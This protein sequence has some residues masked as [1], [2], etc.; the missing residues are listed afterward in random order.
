MQTKVKET[1]LRIQTD[2]DQDFNRAHSHCFLIRL[3][4][5]GNFG[6]EAEFSTVTLSFSDCKRKRTTHPRR[7]I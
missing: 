7:L 3:A 1:Q 6:K 2:I 4:H 5:H